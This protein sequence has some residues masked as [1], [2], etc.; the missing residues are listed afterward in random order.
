MAA[1][2]PA[3]AA[4]GAGAPARLFHGWRIVAV[5]AVTETVSWGVLYYA[6]A[7]FQVPMGAEL[8]FSPV[9]LGGAFSLAVLLTGVAAVPVGRWL[10]A[11]GPR[12]LMSAGSVVCALSSPPG[13]RCTR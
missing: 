7:V 11:R 8:G 13:R 4:P 2:A 3:P 9:V 12:G 10:D 6:F 1:D 5:L